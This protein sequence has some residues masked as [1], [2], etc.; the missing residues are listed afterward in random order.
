[1][2]TAVYEDALV[3]ELRAR[4]RNRAQFKG[5]RWKRT[6][7]WG[8]GSASASGGAFAGSIPGGPLQGPTLETDA[9][10]AQW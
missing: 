5:R 8:S 3:S 1:M 7:A 6:P 4:G 10:V 9:R 2:E